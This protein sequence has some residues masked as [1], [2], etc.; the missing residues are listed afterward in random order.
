MCALMYWHVMSLYVQMV[1]TWLDC[2]RVISC[3][4]N[5]MLYV[6]VDICVHNILT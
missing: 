4:E 2:V 1:I 5:D 3:T 6:D